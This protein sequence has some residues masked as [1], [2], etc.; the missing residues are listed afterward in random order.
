MIAALLLS[1]VQS[2]AAQAKVP[3]SW[4]CEPSR[5]VDGICDCGCTAVDDDCSADVACER[6]NCPD[7]TSVDVDND[8][9]CVDIEEEA[10]AEAEGCGAGAGGAGAGG[11]GAGAG[12]GAAA[13]PLVRLLRRRRQR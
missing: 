9:V 13:I 4:T 7:G 5:F 11:A 10:E 8:N 6:D 1:F 2:V 3:A 12:A